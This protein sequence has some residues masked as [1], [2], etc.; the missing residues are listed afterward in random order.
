MSD[1]TSK[2]RNQLAF[3]MLIVGKLF[4]IGGL[5]LGAT[6]HRIAAGTLLVVDGLMLT[7]AAVLTM[8]NMKKTAVEEKSQKAVL[9]QMMREGTLKQ[10][11]RDIREAQA[12]KTPAA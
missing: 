8:T 10:Y 4:G 3:A 5:I 2:V 12:R 1:S 7:V 9:E 11:I 6:S